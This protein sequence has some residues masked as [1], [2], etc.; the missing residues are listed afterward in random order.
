MYIQVNITKPYITYTQP[1][2][3]QPH[4]ST[5]IFLQTPQYEFN[6]NLYIYTHSYPHTYH[7]TP[8]PL[9]T[10]SL[11][12]TTPSVH[13]TTISYIPSNTPTHNN[14]PSTCTSLH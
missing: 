5:Y 13:F 11:H 10:Q 3:I 6:I 12:A 4:S 2:H 7:A 9:N 8:T 14:K 1:V